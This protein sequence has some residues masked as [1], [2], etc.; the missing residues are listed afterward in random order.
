MDAIDDAADLLLKYGLLD[1]LVTRAAS[2]YWPGT[3]IAGE[4]LPLRHRPW[5]QLLIDYKGLTQSPGLP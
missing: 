3:R 2:R 5:N 4:S 1:L